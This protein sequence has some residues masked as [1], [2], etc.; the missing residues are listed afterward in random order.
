M[1]NTVI[2]LSSA[3]KEQKPEKGKSIPPKTGETLPPGKMIGGSAVKKMRRELGNM[4][5]LI[6][7]ATGEKAEA[8]VKPVQE[9]VGEVEG[10][11]TD[12]EEKVNRNDNTYNAALGE[13]VR[14]KEAAEDALREIDTNTKTLEGVRDE[15]GEMKTKF[16]ENSG[17]VEQ[18]KVQV[19]GIELSVEQLHTH[20]AGKE[21]GLDLRVRE[22]EYDTKER[23]KRIEATAK[24]KVDEVLN[25]F[26]GA[27]QEFELMQNA[28][29]GINTRLDGVEKGVEGARKT[30]DNALTESE[31]ASA[32]AEKALD[33]ANKAHGN[34]SEMDS[35]M[36]SMRRDL[37]RL[38]MT[39]APTPAAEEAVREPSGVAAMPPAPVEVKN[40]NGNGKRQIKETLRKN[41]EKLLEING[42]MG[43][44]RAIVEGLIEGTS[45]KEI[46]ETRELTELDISAYEG[47]DA[48]NKHTQKILGDLTFQLM[49]V[50][51]QRA[52]LDV[53]YDAVKRMARTEGC[54]KELSMPAVEQKTQ[55]ENVKRLTSMN[56]NEIM[57]NTAEKMEIE[58]NKNSYIMSYIYDGIER[59]MDSIENKGD[60]E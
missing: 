53:V 30:A 26:L 3:Q 20:M 40:G 23:I 42:Q 45:L 11:V 49:Q 54:H 6:E 27:M 38:S 35:G 59:V 52:E 16:V 44:G 24:E 17:K 46:S 19:D 33:V 31:T 58:I 22:L 2:N 12:L 57:T 39:P 50:R 48:L 43:D 8:A 37:E 36:H 28:Q 47:Y 13:A 21:K 25:V 41:E 5:G 56:V 9:K 60:G 51:K 29:K 7:E 18:Y 10:R 55:L 15:F 32:A 34:M 1:L 4:G 14:R